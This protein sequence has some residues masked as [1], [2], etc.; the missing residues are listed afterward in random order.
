MEKEGVDFG[1]CTPSFFRS[2][3]VKIHSHGMSRFVPSPTTDNHDD[4]R[5][6]ET[7][8]RF[9]IRYIELIDGRRCGGFGHIEPDFVRPVFLWETHDFA[10]T[11]RQ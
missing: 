4:F 9:H 3:Q 10:V 7:H 5:M 6:G 1:K 8:L 2:T 11:H